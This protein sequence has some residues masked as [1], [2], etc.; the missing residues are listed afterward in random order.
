MTHDA[1]TPPPASGAWRE[2]D[3]PPGERRF[4]DIGRARRSRSAATC[5][6]SASPYETW[7]DAE[8]R[9]RTTRCSCC[10]RS[11][12]TRTSPGRP[13][14]G[15]RPPGWWERL[16]GPGAPIDTDRWFVVAPNVL[17]GCQGT[18]G[19]GL[20]RAGRHGRGARASR[21]SPCATRSP[22]SGAAPTA[23]GIDRVGRGRR[24]LDGR[25]ARAGVG[26]Q[27]PRRACG[28]RWSLAVGAAATAD[29][30]GTQSSAD[31]RDHGR[32][33]LARRRLPRRRA[34]DGPHVGMGIA[35]R[36]AHLTYRSE[37][38]LDDRFGDDA[39]GRRGPADGRPLRRAELPR[40][41]RRQ[42]GPP[43]RRRHVRRAHR[44]D[45]ART[46]S[47]AAAA[48]SQRRSASITVP[49]VVGGRRQRPAL[50]AA[51]AAGARRPDSRRRTGCT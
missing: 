1:R 12:A 9:P 20:A 16:L 10:T 51:P 38:E 6:T 43:V 3:C 18:T 14:P 26:R 28:R 24:R 17:G 13:G 34:G 5:R 7:G 2:G 48:A 49:V 33:G 22:S 23:L 27:P 30:I 35:R 32:P 36:I 25:H 11:P 44:R 47:A 37:V 4:V 40:P 50:P 45:D 19:P 21:A 42:A 46:T 41:P 31:R 8:R 39:A 15:T 29:Q